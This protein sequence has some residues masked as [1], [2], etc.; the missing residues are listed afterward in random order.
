MCWFSSFWC[1]FDL[2]KQNKYGVSMILFRTQWGNGLKLA[3]WCILTTSG[4]DCTLVTVSWFPTYWRHFELNETGQICSFHAFSWECMG[5][6]GWNVSMLMY[7]DFPQDQFD[8]GHGLLI[9]IFFSFHTCSGVPC[10]SDW[11]LMAK[12]CHS[13]PICTST[14]SSLSIQINF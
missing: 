7:P 6:M 8:F 13:Y 14:C 5:G 9:F 12:G 3:G 10:Q 11:P 4:T 2:V 1:H